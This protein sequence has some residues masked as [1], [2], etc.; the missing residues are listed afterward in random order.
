MFYIIFAKNSILSI[1]LQN[2][3]K[4]YYGIRYQM[5]DFSQN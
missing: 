4:S 3:Y 5:Q 1:S 2:Y